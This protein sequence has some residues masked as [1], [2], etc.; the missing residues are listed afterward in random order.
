MWL[1]STITEQILLRRML[2][3][4]HPICKLTNLQLRLRSQS[5]SMLDCGV[6]DW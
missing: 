5:S 1:D 4:Q 6:E 2:L 3:I